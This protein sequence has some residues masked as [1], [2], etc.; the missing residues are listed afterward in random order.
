MEGKINMGWFTKKKEENNI[1]EP[2]EMSPLEAVTHL[3][4]AIQLA[5]GK[6]DYEERESWLLA[7]KNLFP[8]FVEERADRFLNDAQIVLNQKQG[9][10][11]KNYIIGLLSRIKLLLN[12]EQME[13]FGPKIAEL[14]ESDG[15]VMTSEIEIARLIESELKISIILDNDI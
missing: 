1:I 2:S 8:E 7:I 11:K 5:D 4:A 13:N 9:D 3:C 12:K 15:I 6:V 10:D 14:I